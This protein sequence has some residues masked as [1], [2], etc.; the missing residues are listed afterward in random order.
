VN[1]RQVVRRHSRQNEK[2]SLYIFRN[3]GFTLWYLSTTQQEFR[4]VIQLGVVGRSRLA[5]ARQEQ[6]T[7]S[8][9]K[10]T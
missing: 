1:L 9:Y 3:L 8:A 2:F 4:V 10:R 5:G 7:R 6:D